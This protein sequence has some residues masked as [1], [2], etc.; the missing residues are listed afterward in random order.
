MFVPQKKHRV[1]VAR[2]AFERRACAQSVR[3]ARALDRSWCRDA[4]KK[5]WLNRA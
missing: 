4:E 5:V 1:L 2:R 3:D